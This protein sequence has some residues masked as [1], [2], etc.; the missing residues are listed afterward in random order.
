[1][2]ALTIRDKAEILDVFSTEGDWLLGAARSSAAFEWL[3]EAGSS[4]VRDALMAAGGG[5]AVFSKRPAGWEPPV[6]GWYEWPGAGGA[7][8]VAA[9]FSVGDP[10]L[11]ELP[12]ETVA[13]AVSPDGTF[14]SRTAWISVPSGEPREEAVSRFLAHLSSSGVHVRRLRGQELRERV[15]ESAFGSAAGRQP[16][17]RPAA[18]G[19]RLRATGLLGPLQSALWSAV[20]RAMSAAED[21]FFQSVGASLSREA[22]AA[23]SPA[24][25]K[26]DY[27]VLTPGGYLGGLVFRGFP[28]E[29][30]D[31]VGFLGGILRPGE[32]VSV[33]VYP[34]SAHMRRAEIRPDAFD[35]AFGPSEKAVERETWYLQVAVAFREAVPYLLDVRCRDFLGVIGRDFFAVRADGR[36]SGFWATVSGTGLNALK[37]E[38]GYD[39]GEISGLITF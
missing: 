15:S 1:M 28:K 21:A 8:A 7:R 22:A 5:Q 17:A 25:D 11:R 23:L 13:A 20:R 26:L 36:S 33:H 30:I 12:R 34:G 18:R 3:A 2:E 6:S 27:A 19:P 38:L 29:N 32:S 37:N 31:V 24:A 35:G 4:A 39:A 9:D 14:V 10:S 16:G